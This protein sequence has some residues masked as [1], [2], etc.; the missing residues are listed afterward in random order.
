MS[1]DDPRHVGPA[2]SR[3]DVDGHVVSQ[4]PAWT[5]TGLREH[6]SR[7][8]A[9]GNAAA[10]LAAA[11][12]LIEESDRLRGEAADAFSE[13]H[14]IAKQVG[15]AQA[16][17]AAQ[18][19][20]LAHEQHNLSEAVSGLARRRAA[21][22]DLQAELMAEKLALDEREDL[23]AARENDVMAR[24]QALEEFLAQKRVRR[25][26]VEAPP[27]AA[28]IDSGPLDLRP[29]PLMAIGEHQFMECLRQFK[30]YAGNRSTRD[31]SEYCGGMISA[32]TVGNVLRSDTLPD[33]LEVVD[34]IVLGSGGSDADRAD[35]QHAWRRLYISR[36]RTDIRRIPG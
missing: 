23:L 6:V 26:Q 31:I 33:R 34:A 2:S 19:E 12:L 29:D 22:E 17:L 15:A 5:P 14:R 9:T 28:F 18:R 10:A 21:L 30:I 32:S 36:T 25:R 27:A 7:L 16:Q 24:E 13:T 1:G 11:H 35:F 8:I 4:G 3:A 20:R